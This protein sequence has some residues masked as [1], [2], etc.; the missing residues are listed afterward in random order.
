MNPVWGIVIVLVIIC[1]ATFLV[2]K[3]GR[4]KYVVGYQ[5]TGHYLN[6]DPYMV[7]NCGKKCVKNNAPIQRARSTR[8]VSD[9]EP[10]M[11]WASCRPDAPY[12]RLGETK[13]PLCDKPTTSDEHNLYWQYYGGPFG[14]NMSPY[15]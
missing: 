2:L 12:A 7:K 9:F 8:D 3:F 4:S 6:G 14:W 13:P 5:V 11:P 1:L 15:Y 10:L